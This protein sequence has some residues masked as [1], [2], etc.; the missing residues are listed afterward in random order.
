MSAKC[1][2]RWKFRVSQD[3]LLHVRFCPKCTICEYIDEYRGWST[4]RYSDSP[5]K[6]PSTY[7]HSTHGKLTCE[8]DPGHLHRIGDVSHQRGETI[9]M[10][11]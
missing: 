2:H 9:W 6:C 4:M 3:G 8:K 10:S 1:S 11:V 7:T 5:D